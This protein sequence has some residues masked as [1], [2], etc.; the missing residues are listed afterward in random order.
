MS[1]L[2]KYDVIIVGAG[3]AGALMGYELA[4]LGL[5]AL[6]IEKEVLPRY[7]ACGGGLTRRALNALPFDIS[8][9]IEDS[10]TC[11]LF[12]TINRPSAGT[13]SPS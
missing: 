12:V 8:P 11:R 7:K 1:L 6:L 4:R 5:K 13:L 2:P 3:P 10:S 9:V